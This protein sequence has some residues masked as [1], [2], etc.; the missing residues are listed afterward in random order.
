MPTTGNVVSTPANSLFSNVSI[1]PL[2]QM[3]APKEPVL[4]AEFSGIQVHGQNFIVV[5]PRQ[6]LWNIE[7]PPYFELRRMRKHGTIQLGRILAA[8]PTLAAS[9]APVVD[10]DTPEEISNF[11]DW[12]IEI[13]PSFMERAVF[14][15]IDYGWY[16][17]ETIPVLNEDGYYYPKI[18][19]LLPDLNQ[20]VIAGDGTFQ[21]FV[22]ILRY[23]VPV[24]KNNALYIGFRVEGQQHYGQG[25]LNAAREHWQDWL[26]CNIGATQYDK[27]VAGSM[28]EVCY[29]DGESIWMDNQPHPNVEIAAFILNNLEAGRGIIRPVSFSQYIST[30]NN[31]NTLNLSES[32]VKSL[33]WAINILED[34][35]PR[36]SHFVDRLKYLDQLLLRA[37]FVPERVAIEASVAGSRADAEA[38][39]DIFLMYAEFIHQQ[40]TAAF[41]EQVVDRFVEINFGKQWVGKAR[42]KCASL[43][44]DKKVYL[45]ELIKEIIAQPELLQKI[46]I[47]SILETL[48]LDINEDDA[49]GAETEPVDPNV[50]FVDVRNG[51]AYTAQPG[52]PERKEFATKP[53]KGE[54]AA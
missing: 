29:P 49:V 42:I 11:I 24:P 27:K 31:I 2:N 43:V 44:D 8:A 46:N 38:H 17:A 15:D 14:A 37:L 35:T 20:I 16:A 39:T 25:R 54:S 1:W 3:E 28:Y 7:Q 40:I 12:L 51:D 41:N 32:D 21:G 50:K 53:S 33:G 26:N 4:N 52:D 19:H 9:W 13:R 30:L 18:K 36:Q 47:E 22:Q 23:D 6:I 34:N 45:R 5:V 48:G 10:D